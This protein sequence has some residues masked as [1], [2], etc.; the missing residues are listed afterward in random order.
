MKLLFCG[1]ASGAISK[2]VVS[3]LARVT[4]LFQVQGTG[5]KNLRIPKAYTDSI[6]SSIKNI[7]VN[8]GIIMQYQLDSESAFY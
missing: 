1:G 8:E 2:T 4:V 3:P 6:F 5:D 7:Y